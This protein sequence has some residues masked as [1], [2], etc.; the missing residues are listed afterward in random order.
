MLGGNPKVEMAMEEANARGNIHEGGR[1]A[2]DY[3][4]VVGKTKNM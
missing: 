2:G 4:G 3:C 1:N